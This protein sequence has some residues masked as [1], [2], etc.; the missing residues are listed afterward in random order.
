MK[1]ISINQLKMSLDELHNNNHQ[2]LEQFFILF[3]KFMTINMFYRECIKD[4]FTH[5]KKESVGHHQNHL[6]QNIGNILAITI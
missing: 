5:L 2:F 6:Y 1:D 3:N 4:D